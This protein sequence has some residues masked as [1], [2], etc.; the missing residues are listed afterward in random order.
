MAAELA[1]PLKRGLDLERE[2]RYTEAAT[3]YR[4]AVAEDPSLLE[5]RVRL[6]V[7]LREL[8]LDEEANGVFLGALDRVRDLDLA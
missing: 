7:V 5:A 8:G 2:G 6:G 1:T 4:E 3:A